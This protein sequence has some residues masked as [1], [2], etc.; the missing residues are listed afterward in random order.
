MI[1]SLEPPQ[2]AA[3]LS[4]QLETFFPDGKSPAKA[5]EASL[6][7]SLARLGKA[8]AFNILPPNFK[9][10]G[11]TYFNHLFSDQYAMFLY[12]VSNELGCQ[13]G[14]KEAAT[15]VYLLNKLLHSIDVYYEVKLPE[16][17]LFAHPMGTVLGRATYHDYLLVMQNCTVGNIEGIYPTLGEGCALCAGAM[18]LGNSVLEE[19]VTVGAG[20]MAVNVNVPANHVLIGRGSQSRIMPSEKPMWTKYFK[21]PSFR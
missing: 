20:S 4:R 13:M 17:F 12:L 3:F 21:R 16:I 7:N 6:D 1:T 18:V 15:K 2:I 8:I 14:E 5:V 10:D 9:R 19:G 11:Q